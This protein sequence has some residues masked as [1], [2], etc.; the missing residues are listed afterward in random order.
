VI[1]QDLVINCM[2]EERSDRHGVVKRE[3]HRCYKLPADIDTATVK[4][5]LSAK[6]ILQVT[7]AKKK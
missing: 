6:G 7:A 4:S 2:H 3:I 1:G 5:K